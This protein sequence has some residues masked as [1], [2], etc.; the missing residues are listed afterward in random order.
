MTGYFSGVAI[1]EFVFGASKDALVVDM[2][3]DPA[4]TFAGAATWKRKE[5]PVTMPM[6]RIPIATIVLIFLWNCLRNR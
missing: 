2:T 1:G 4:L 6:E 3:C 5:K